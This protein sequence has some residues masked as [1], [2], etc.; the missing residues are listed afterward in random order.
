[1]GGGHPLLDPPRSLRSFA[2]YFR[3]HVNIDHFQRRSLAYYYDEC[4]WN[5]ML[6][7]W[8]YRLALLLFGGNHISFIFAPNIHQKLYFLGGLQMQKCLCPAYYDHE[9]IW[10][11]MLNVSVLSAYWRLYLSAIPCPDPSPARSLCS[12]VYYFR[13][14]WVGHFQKRSFAS[15]SR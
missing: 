3:R 12:L 1:M 2:D 7:A 9:C 5:G 15:P 14:H 4:I 8:Y 11:S 13:R 10:N 6:N